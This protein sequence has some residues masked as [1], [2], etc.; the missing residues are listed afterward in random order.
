MKKSFLFNTLL[1]IVAI[2]MLNIQGVQAQERKSPKL[3]QLH[4][5]EP[6]E[7]KEDGGEFRVKAWK[8]IKG[9]PADDALVLGMFSHHV[10]QGHKNGTNNMVA[11][12]Y[13]GFAAGTFKNSFWVQS[14]YAAVSR[15]VYEK[16]INKDLKMDV[17]YKAGIIDGYGERYFNL[18]GLT[19]IVLPQIGVTYKKVG[20]DIWIIP[21]GVVAVNFRLNMPEFKKN[22]TE[23]SK[24]EPPKAEA[25]L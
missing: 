15:K 5:E 23:P 18:G 3:F 11:G 8:F 10:N 24:T 12:Q 13:K 16:Q 25:V 2:F 14:Y 19:P 22:K 1:L 21:P 6:H 17:Q 9:K 7:I 4:V 20:A